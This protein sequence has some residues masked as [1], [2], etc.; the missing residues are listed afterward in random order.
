MADKFLSDRIKK[1]PPTEVSEDRYSYFRPGEVEP[2]FGVPLAN[3]AIIS[4]E[5]D[6]TRQWLYPSSGLSVQAN[7]QLVVDVESI[8]FTSNGL[9]YTAANTLFQAVTDIER[10]AYND[11]QQRLITVSIDTT[12]VGDGT[13]NNVLGVNPDFLSNTIASTVTTGFINDLNVDADT[14]DGRQFDDYLNQP[15]RSTDTVAFDTA[16]VTHINFNTVH[17]D[18]PPE[19]QLCWN[20]N[21][22]TLNL[23]LAGN[24]VILQVGQ[25]NVFYV[26]N[27]T[28]S[29]IP[30][31][32]VVAITG[33][34]S[35]R[36]TIAP[37]IADGTFLAGQIGGVATED[38]AVDSLGF[39]STYG[40]VRDVNTSAF[41]VGTYLYASANV[42][43][44]FVSEAPVA[45][46]LKVV[47]GMVVVQDANTGII[48]VSPTFSPAAGDITYDNTLST[49]IATNVQTAIDEL[50]AI[51]AD[52]S[53]LSSTLYLYATT[54]NSDVVGYGTIV[55]S[56]SDFRYDDI[57]VDL[58][59]GPID[60]SNTLVAVVISDANII[61]GNPGVINTT[62]F[63][64]L[65]KTSGVDNA[66]F[67]YELYKRDASN[68]EILI[69]RSSTTTD[70]TSLT[71]V[72]YS[73]SSL[74]NNPTFVSTDRIVARFYG[75]KSGNTDNPTYDFQVGGS[76]PIRILIPVP[77]S[78]IP[79]SIA[80]DI[81]VDT[82]QFNGI[83]SPTDGTVQL[84]LDRIDDHTHTTSEIAEGSRLYY[85]ATRANQAIDTRVTKT[86]VDNLNVDADTFDG[87]D[88]VYYLDYNNLNNKPVIGDGLLTVTSSDG[89]SGS[90][91]FT[92]NQ[93][94]PSN[95]A[96]TNTDRGSSQEIFKTIL[97][98]GQPTI[99]ADNNSDSL[100]FVAG[101]NVSLTTSA[102]NNQI[103][104]SSTT[105]S[106][107]NYVDAVSFNADTGTLTLGRTGTLPDLNVTIAA[108][109]A[110][111][112]LTIVYD[113]DGSSVTGGASIDLL[114]SDS[115][116][117]S[118]LVKGSGATTV[119]WSEI[120]QTIDIQ[121]VDTTYQAG[122]GLDL[123][124]TTFSHEDTSSVPNLLTAVD[125]YIS[126]MS[127]DTYGHVTGYVTSSITD[128]Y[129]DSIVFD[130]NTAMLTLGRTGALSD[131]SVELTGLQFEEVDTLDSVVT[132]G[133]TTAG[134][135]VV[136]SL[137]ANG[138][139]YAPTFIGNLNGQISDISNF[140]TDDLVE[141]SVNFYF[142]PERANNV[143]T[144]T[145]TKE[146][147]DGLG[148]DAATLGGALP[149]F[150]LNYENLI[151]K[152]SSILDFGVIDGNAGD[153]LVTD[154]NGSFSFQPVE[155][156]GQT[157]VF[158]L[159]QDDSAYFYTAVGDLYD[160][161]QPR[162]PDKS[163][164]INNAGAFSGY[165]TLTFN[166]SDNTL[167][168]TNLNATNSINSEGNI[169][170]LNFNTNGGDLSVVGNATIDGDLDV[171][172]L[173]GYSVDAIH[174]RGQLNSSDSAY[175]YT[176][177]EEVEAN[178]KEP[179]LILLQ[180][181][182]ITVG[183]AA[184][185][186][187]LPAGYSRYRLILNGIS[188]STEQ[189]GISMRVSIDE[190]ASFISTSDYK[191]TLQIVEYGATNS[192]EGDATLTN[193]LL[194][195][196]FS[197]AAATN[198][199]M[200][201]DMFIGSDYV[202]ILGGSSAS[203]CM[204]YGGGTKITASRTNAVRIFPLLYTLIAGT[205]SLYAYKEDI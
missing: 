128:N 73:A 113:L 16:N 63:G 20:S 127:F 134:T 186:F 152:P 37:Y 145:V 75:L 52:S 9:Y 111:S 172:T 191:S 158:T 11:I 148:I 15:V 123:T 27:N 49:L 194:T 1:I 143:V 36:I 140:S 112:T 180:Q 2:D 122:A 166:T 81:L 61:D 32:T 93:T 64:N 160:K 86:F 92:A 68:N 153:F 107:D 23:G 28:E 105:S 189:I 147:V 183:V 125:V 120:D 38:I 100:E 84:A 192:S 149:A 25:E 29:L 4:S 117:D 50:D 168:T 35:G 118:I 154:G 167:T 124:G 130:A 97:V 177:I 106:E 7:N 22:G 174:D 144:G 165:S 96:L 196:S 115:T 129:V 164:Q 69:S 176:K 204:T 94:A 169:T 142:T 6:G 102:N 31:G 151:N 190:G 187:I 135:L 41:N 114:G 88:S 62:V 163:I 51:K 91:T 33:A 146:F 3:N 74:L 103:I 90:G 42:A 53:A 126:G 44:A 54:A 17:V 85:T 57:A 40:F 198:Q 162:G 80:S 60:S 82:S 67:F 150:Y 136:G 170:A 34:Q 108:L 193:F 46:N 18:T 188:T 55:E 12:L 83:L 109:S 87:Q 179:G 173:N 70:V 181:E 47:V 203:S 182:V 119:S 10:N 185:D 48:A 156:N 66:K 58:S 24:N 201:Y 175:F 161:S 99:V 195:G 76:D 104:I 77:V 21:D 8:P 205:I 159:L 178:I 14:W 184:V 132:R 43:G 71:Y 45:P 199:D 171:V 116:S 19:G 5:V 202:S 78:V 121:S 101:T 59:T 133:N 13:A 200:I 65:R 72:Q 141:G 56:T 137:V 39:I 98:A 110:N 139:V 95:I 138:D 26:R 89:L 155:G 131:L 79:D 30:N 157:D 197:G